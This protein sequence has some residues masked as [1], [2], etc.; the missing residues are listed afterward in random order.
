[1]YKTR[2]KPLT[3][4]NCQDRSSREAPSFSPPEAFIFL[5][6]KEKF[7]TLKEG[8]I[9]IWTSEGILLT[10]FDGRQLCT[11]MDMNGEAVQPGSEDPLHQQP[12][13][14]N[15]IVSVSQSK[16][17][18]FAYQIED[19]ASAYGNAIDHSTERSFINVIDIQ[20]EQIIA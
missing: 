18:L 8:R 7:L 9:E 12:G 17:Y 6:E 14:T 2:G 19:L 15:Y 16:R 20:N 1:M 11:R 4:I 5:Y 10:D 13:A 3:I